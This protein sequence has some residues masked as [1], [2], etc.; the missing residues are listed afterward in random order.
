MNIFLRLTLDCDADAAWDALSNPEVFAAVSSPLLKF[1]S[2]EKDGFP[3]AWTGQG[4]HLVSVKLF[5]IFPLG[6]QTIDATFTQRPGG[7]RMMIDA[8][9]PQSGALAAIKKWD[10]RMAVSSPAPGKTLY[11]DRLQFSAGWLTPL[12]FI[13]LWFF[14]QRRGAKLSKLAKSWN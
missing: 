12:M 7:V 1:S 3:P 4:P 8:G 14:W 13:P 5:G 6:T 9:S 11:R 2:Q 10:H